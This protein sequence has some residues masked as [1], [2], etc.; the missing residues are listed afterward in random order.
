MQGKQTEI[1][2]D[3]DRQRSEFY[4][5][6]WIDV[7]GAVKAALDAHPEYLTEKGKRFRSARRSI[8]KRVVGQV[9]ATLERMVEENRETG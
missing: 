6:L 8:V 4:R 1:P 5:K 9:F 2:A 3:T 7:D